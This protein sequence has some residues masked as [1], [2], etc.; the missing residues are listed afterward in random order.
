MLRGRQIIS[1]DIRNF[2]LNLGLGNRI[3]D[4]SPCGIALRA[5]N[6]ILV[7]SVFHGARPVK[8]RHRCDTNALAVRIFHGASHKGALRWT[9]GGEQSR[10]TKDAKFGEMGKYFSLRS[11]RLG[12][13][14]FVEAFS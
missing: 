7:E 3:N 5:N 10:T 6:S 13:K 8:Y 11:W 2:P 4:D 1:K 9:Q 14:I 12:E